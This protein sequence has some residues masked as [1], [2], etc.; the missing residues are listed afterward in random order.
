MAKKGFHTASQAIADF[1]KFV[2]PILNKVKA[3]HIVQHQDQFKELIEKYC[4]TYRCG[5][6]KSKE[7]IWQCCD[8]L[9]R[10]KHKYSGIDSETKEVRNF[11]RVHYKTQKRKTIKT[12]TKATDLEINEGEEVRIENEQR[13]ETKYIKEISFASDMTRNIIERNTFREKFLMH[14]STEYL[15]QIRDSSYKSD[16]AFQH[17]E[18]TT[19]MRDKLST[20]VDELCSDVRTATANDLKMYNLRLDSITKAIDTARRIDM[21]PIYSLNMISEGG[22]NAQKEV[23][24]AIINDK[25]MVDNGQITLE[26]PKELLGGDSASEDLKILASALRNRLIEGV[27][28]KVDKVDMDVRKD[29]HPPTTLITDENTLDLE[30][31]DSMVDEN[32]NNLTNSTPKKPLKDITPQK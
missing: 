9:R 8:R 24:G 11:I 19:K 20:I 29:P 17:L 28:D 21:S 23:Q 16:Y 18:I 7:E 1:R 25:T 3:M 13:I 22:F 5:K 12:L 6:P 30:P 10:I 15:K 31:V 26:K 32:F 27:V 14:F 4:A 2:I